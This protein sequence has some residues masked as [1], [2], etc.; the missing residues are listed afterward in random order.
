MSQPAEIEITGPIED[1]FDEVLTRTMCESR[2]CRQRASTACTV[3]TGMPSRP[4]IRDVRRGH[5]IKMKPQSSEEYRPFRMVK[6]TRVSTTTTRQNARSGAEILV[7]QT[8]GQVQ[9][10]TSGAGPPQQSI[11]A[12]QASIVSDRLRYTALYRAYP[13]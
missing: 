2:L 11:C 8:H 12:T 13:R 6:Q 9:G 1:R 4:P 7:R 10:S 5:R 3:E